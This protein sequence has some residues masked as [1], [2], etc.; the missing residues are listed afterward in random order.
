VKHDRIDLEPL[1]KDCVEL[2]EG[3]ASERS[4]QIEIR[5]SHCDVFGDWDRLA[6]VITNLLTNAINYNVDGGHIIISTNIEN[7]TVVITVEDN[8]IG[9]AEDQLPKIFDRFYQVDASRSH[10]EGSCGLGLSICKTIVELHGGTIAA[11]SRL[12]TGTRIEIRLPVAE[13]SASTSSA[14]LQVAELI[15][16][17]SSA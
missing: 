9:I 7:K 15:G 17:S 1:I 10:A 8:G 6:Q 12:N 11:T 5:T 3:I 16:S 14:V 4:I 13:K 2:V